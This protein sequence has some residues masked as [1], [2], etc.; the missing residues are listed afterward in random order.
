MYLVADTIDQ[1]KDLYKWE[2]RLDLGKRG[3][4]EGSALIEGLDADKIYYVR[5]YASNS[6][7]EDWTGKESQVRLQPLANHLP[8]GLGM[9]LDANDILADGSTGVEGVSLSTWRDKSMFGRDMDNFLG[10]PQIKF[11]G[12]GDKPVVDFDGND[13]MWTTYDL[14]GPDFNQW[15]SLGYVAFGVSRYTGGDS[16]R[17]ISSVGYNWL[18]GHHGNRISRYYLNG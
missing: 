16:E 12:Y 14:A 9:W 5:L 10:D 17:V 7:G 2:Y 11:D 6:A 8:I 3:L 15:R 1:G 4:G 18:M 13:Q